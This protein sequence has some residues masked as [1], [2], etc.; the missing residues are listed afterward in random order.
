MGPEGEVYKCYVF[1]PRRKNIR[2]KVAQKQRN[3][4]IDSERRLGARFCVECF[5]EDVE[6]T[7]SSQTSQLRSLR[8]LLYFSAFRNGFSDLWASIGHF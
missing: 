7:A 8:V 6:T 2:K 3:I 4:Y 5:Q 1:T